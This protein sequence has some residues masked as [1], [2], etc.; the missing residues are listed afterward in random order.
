MI[1]Q[2][3]SLAAYRTRSTFRHRW[4]G[5]LALIVLLARQISAV[6][7]PTVSV[8]SVVLVALGTVLLANLVAALP[9]RAA[10]RMPTALMLRAE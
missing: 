3:L 5:Y 4:G 7:Y 10:A 2:R 9:A 6:P 8:P 1:E